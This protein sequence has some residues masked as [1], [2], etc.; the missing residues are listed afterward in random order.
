VAD[1]AART[2]SFAVGDKDGL[3]A[4]PCARIARAAQRF[5]CEVVAVWNGRRADATSVLELLGLNAPGGALVEFTATGRDA[6]ACLEA[7]GRAVAEP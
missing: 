2:A 5:R 4:R 1:A 6:A 7:V 3:H